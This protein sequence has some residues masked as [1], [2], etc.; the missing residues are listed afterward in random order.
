[1]GKVAL[2]FK[3]EIYNFC[4]L[5]REQEAKG[6]CLSWSFRHGGIAKHLLG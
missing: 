6:P 3:G 5:R 1:M 4:E 2:V